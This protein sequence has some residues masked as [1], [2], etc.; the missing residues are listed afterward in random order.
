M[1]SQRW[2]SVI[3]RQVWQFVAD[4]GLAAV[5]TTATASTVAKNRFDMALRPRETPT[6]NDRERR[7]NS[8]A[9]ERRDVPQGKSSYLPVGVY[10][11]GEV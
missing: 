10:Q 4:A 5:A 3:R 8:T 9:V 1:R 2:S 11:I 7:C 6:L